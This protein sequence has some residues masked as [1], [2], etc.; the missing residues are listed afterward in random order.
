M[1]NTRYKIIMVDDNQTN[2]T[3]GKSMLKTF[4]EIIPL[5]S[6]AE[7]FTALEKVIP[8]LILLDV[9]MP[10]MNGYEAIKKLKADSRFSDIPV[11]FL[12]VLDDAGSELEGL[13][14]GAADYV[15]KPFSAPLLI[16]RIE[17]EL[18]IVKQRKELLK[19]HASLSDYADNLET[20]VREK[21]DQVFNLQN[22]VLHTVADLVE[23]RDRSTGKHITRTGLYLKAMTDEM[24]RKEVY[25][26]EI[27]GWDMDFFL[28]SALLH[29]VGK[30]AISDLILNKP[31][32]LTDD[33][34]AIMKTHVAVGVDAI[35]RIID[36]TKKHSFLHHALS[37]AGT[38][39]ERW[40]GKGYPLGLKGCGIP[41][42]GR[43]MAIAD[44]YDA[45][46]SVRPYKKSF[47]HEESCK[48]IEDGS[49][50]QFDPSLVDVFR[51]IKSEFEQIALKFGDGDTAAVTS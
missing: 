21:T 51:G 12:T 39:H 28:P 3:I 50:T 7:L 25:K 35:E 29:D 47:S 16:K 48:I 37:T 15:T 2:L 33:E 13:E 8:D 11:I 43:L 38:H 49:G 31:G 1:S 45:L 26:E 34:F 6:A 40:D 27:S 23:Y 18:L 42:E 36:N 44:V 9:E 10:E 41:L 30:I 14:L 32:K 4:F 5:P 20:R 46:I 22:S 19:A 17:K 24:I